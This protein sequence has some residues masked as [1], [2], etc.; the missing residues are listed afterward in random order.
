V[1][2]YKLR[3]AIMKTKKVI[4]THFMPTSELKL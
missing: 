4:Q 2:D 3:R 1:I